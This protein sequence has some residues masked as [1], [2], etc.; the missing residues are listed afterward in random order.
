MALM[1]IVIVAAVVCVVLIRRM[2]ASD[3]TESASPGASNKESMLPTEAISEL[4]NVHKLVGRWLRTDSPY[5][6]EIREVGP[7]GTL[8]AGYYNPKPINVSAAKVENKNSTL[9][10]SVELHDTVYPGS[11]YTLNYDPE[12]DALEGNYFQATLLQKFDVAFMRMPAEC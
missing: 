8:R 2:G 4:V 6:I 1:L 11:N 7:G 3:S 5:V 12:N 9:Q 10:V